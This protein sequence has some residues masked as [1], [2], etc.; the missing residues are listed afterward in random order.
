VDHLQFFNR[1]PKTGDS[2]RVVNKF[3][4]KKNS[5]KPIAKFTGVIITSNGVQV[6]GDFSKRPAVTGTFLPG[7]GPEQLLPQNDGWKE[8]K[9]ISGAISRAG[10]GDWERAAKLGTARDSLRGVTGQPDRAAFTIP[11]AGIGSTIGGGIGRLL[12]IDDEA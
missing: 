6:G 3:I 10:G 8:L 7:A 11:A 9:G 1:P 5:T 4:N 12:G 2:L